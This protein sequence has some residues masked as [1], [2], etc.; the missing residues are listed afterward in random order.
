MPMRTP[1][2]IET[3]K[4][5]LG[6]RVSVGG[7]SIPQKAATVSKGDNAEETPSRKTSKTSKKGP[8]APAMSLTQRLEL[9]QMVNSLHSSV[10]RTRNRATAELRSLSWLYD[11]IPYTDPSCNRGIVLSDRVQQSRFLALCLNPE[12]YRD[13]IIMYVDAHDN[14]YLLDGLQT[15]STVARVLDGALPIYMDEQVFLDAYPSLEIDG[16]PKKGLLFLSNID[17]SDSQV[18]YNFDREV[19]TPTWK[20]PKAKKKRERC[21][22]NVHLWSELMIRAN[23]NEFQGC[24][25][26]CQLE[27]SQYVSESIVSK[28]REDISIP[29]VELKKEHGWT[30]EDASAYVA[31]IMCNREP[32]CPHEVCMILHTSA[33]RMLKDLAADGTASECLSKLLPNVRSAHFAVLLSAALLL[34]GGPGAPGSDSS[35]NFLK[36]LVLDLELSEDDIDSLKIGLNLLDTMPKFP[37]PNKERIALAIAYLAKYPE[38]AVES[39]EVLFKHTNKYLKGEEGGTQ[40]IESV[41]DN[42]MNSFLAMERLMGTGDGESTRVVEFSPREGDIHVIDLTEL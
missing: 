16:E 19:D 38:T 5:S 10:G 32:L 15:L 37:K 26:H 13:P 30:L 7:G 28:I 20:V 3:L 34:K 27:D 31:E 22:N 23:N 36:S 9:H 4:R 17:N 18:F 35:H 8:A 12:A 33:V 29:V 39:V 24:E 41:K 25:F 42:L 40:F 6:C 1:K 14:K 2:Q 21:E 11:Q